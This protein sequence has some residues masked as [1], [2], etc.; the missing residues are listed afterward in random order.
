MQS[1]RISLKPPPLEVDV[2]PDLIKGKEI[3]PE[4]YSNVLIC[5]KKK[6]GKTNVLYHMLR[7]ILGKDS[8][9]LCFGPT[10]NKDPMYKAIK[11]MAAAKGADPL[12]FTHFID[13][14]GTSL[15]DEIIE[16]NGQAPEQTSRPILKPKPVEHKQER[17]LTEL[18]QVKLIMG[19]PIGQPEPKPEEILEEIEEKEH[20]KAARKRKL[21]SKY[22]LV[23]DDLGKQMY[24]DVISDFMIQNRHH[25]CKVFVL[26]QHIKFLN[27]AARAQLDYVLLFPG[28]SADKLISLHEDLDLP[29]DFDEFYRMYKQATSKKYNFLFIDTAQA[30]YKHNFDEVMNEDE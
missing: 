13:K 2:N 21:V 29:G 20:K 19:L 1:S 15:L 11:K 22:V 28:F 8:H 26:V 16:A 30:K 9:L 25:E 7:R 17:Q 5:G 4:L 24:S 6:S 12:F 27:K 14:D 18:E 10:V 3:I 23:F